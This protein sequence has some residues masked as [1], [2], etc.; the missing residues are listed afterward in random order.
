MKAKYYIEIRHSVQII[1]KFLFKIMFNI[2]FCKI[3]YVKEKNLHRVQT[4]FAWK[5][6]IHLFI[7]FAQKSS[8]FGLKFAYWKKHEKNIILYRMQ[9][10]P[11]CDYYLRKY[12]C[13]KK[14]CTYK[15]RSVSCAKLNKIYIKSSNPS[16]RSLEIVIFGLKF[17]YEWRKHDP[18]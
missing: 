2:H 14:H 8:F 16:L 5:L 3:L 12:F 7:S 13:A 6:Q 10:N 4:K 15:K 11:N 9:S 18:I 17:A 1:Q